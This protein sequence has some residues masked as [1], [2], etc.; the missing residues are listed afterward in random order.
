MNRLICLFFYVIYQFSFTFKHG[1]AFSTF[2]KSFISTDFKV[3]KF[4]LEKLYS[5]DV[6]CDISRSVDPILNLINC[7]IGITFAKNFEDEPVIAAMQSMNGINRGSTLVFDR[8]GELKG[9][10]TERDFVTKI[11]DPEKTPS[12]IKLYE[13]MTPISKMILGDPKMLVRDCQKIMNDNK[14]RHL[15]IVDDKKSVLAVV[16]RSELVRVL[17]EDFQARESASLFGDTILDIEEQQKELSN[18]LALEQGT[19][20]SNRDILRTGFVISGAVALA[21]LLQANWVH[22]HEWLSMSGIFLLGYVGI[23]FENYFEFHKAAIALL[24]ATALW[25]IF[26]GQAGGTGL[27]MPEALHDLSEKVSETSEV[28]FFILGAM[29]IVEIVDAHKGFKVV[30]DLIQS[31]TT[32]GLMW[33]ISFITFFMSAVLDNLTTTILMVLFYYF[34]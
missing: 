28:V 26:A 4:K 32:R 3:N 6:N 18:Q 21:A 10:F 1:I 9:I 23:I 24:M 15:P 31:K 27:T 20:G 7:G 5:E 12:Q 14:I 22:D 19:E 17:A 30:T 2:R 8:G 33:V 34:F 13:V 16:S 11:V 29:T 25:V